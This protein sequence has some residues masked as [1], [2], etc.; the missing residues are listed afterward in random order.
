MVQGLVYSR[1]SLYHSVNYE[2]V[3]CFGRGRAVKGNEEKT[4][5][6]ERMIDRYHPG[7]TAGRDY[8][9]ASLKDLKAT[10][11]VE[12]LIEEMSAKVRRGGP[13]GPRDAEPDAPGTCGVT[14][15]GDSALGKIHA[16]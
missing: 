3:V 4:G 6:F 5:L 9:E 12:V 10:A 2:S 1:S 7:R 16:G 11:L 15:F 14:P 13:L 8:A